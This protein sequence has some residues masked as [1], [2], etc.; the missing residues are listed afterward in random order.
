MSIIEIYAQLFGLRWNDEWLEIADNSPRQE[1][2]DYEQESFRH[3][4]YNYL[5]DILRKEERV[6]LRNTDKSDH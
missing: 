1:P 6:W 2:C 3:S 5:E 4:T